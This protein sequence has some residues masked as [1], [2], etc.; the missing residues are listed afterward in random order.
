M[1]V[2]LKLVLKEVFVLLS[3]VLTASGLILCIT[4]I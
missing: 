1:S 2:A 4:C 3:N